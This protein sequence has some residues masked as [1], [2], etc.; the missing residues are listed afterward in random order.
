MAVAVVRLATRERVVQFDQR[1]QGCANVLAL[2]IYPYLVS[3]RSIKRRLF[4]HGDDNDIGRLTL[5]YNAMDCDNATK[6]DEGCDEKPKRTC[7]G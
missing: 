5:A 2:G 4:M 3:Q 1:A 6:D 7:L